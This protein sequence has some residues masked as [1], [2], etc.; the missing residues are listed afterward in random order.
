[1]AQW[2]S[3]QLTEARDEAPSLS[4][5]VHGSW[6]PKMVGTHHRGKHGEVPGESCI[7]AWASPVDATD[8]PARV[9]KLALSADRD[10]VIP[11]FPALVAFPE[12]RE[13]DH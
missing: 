12:E 2:P 4:V 1:M 3:P 10:P 8:R 11:A 9:D 6:W 5:M 7:T 13:L